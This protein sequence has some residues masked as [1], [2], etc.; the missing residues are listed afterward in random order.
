MNKQ[1]L[2]LRPRQPYNPL[3]QQKLRRRLLKLLA[4]K[5]MRGV[6]RWMNNASSVI[7]NYALALRK[8]AWICQSKRRGK[9]H[10]PPLMTQQ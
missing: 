3:R 5:L 8:S 1:F 6:R 4:L 7:T 10:S 2:L 9:C